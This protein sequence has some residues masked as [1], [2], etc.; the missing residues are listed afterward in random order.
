M[1][2]KV[3]HRT[4]DRTASGGLWGLTNPGLK[5]PGAP[6]PKEKRVTTLTE[7]PPSINTAIHL[8]SHAHHY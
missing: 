1:K 4:S 3:W 8:L 5:P 6:T 7:L 2:T